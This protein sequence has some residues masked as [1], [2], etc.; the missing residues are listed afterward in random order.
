MYESLVSNFVRTEDMEFQQSAIL[1]IG[2]GNSLDNND[3]QDLLEWR[4]KQGYT[5]YT[6][7]TSEAGTSEN[8]IKDFIQYAYED[9]EPQP[10]FICLMGDVGGTYNIPTFTENL[11]GYSGSGDNPYGLL[12][13]N[14]FKNKW[15]E[16]YQ[17]TK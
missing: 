13:G 2:G 7:S 9:F 11:S 16:Y 17:K 8:S 1:V 5:V 3:V 6:V 12:S 4:H 15:Q 10:E 14:E